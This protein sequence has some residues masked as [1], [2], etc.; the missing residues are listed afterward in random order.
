MASGG[1]WQGTQARGPAPVISGG[2]DRAGSGLLGGPGARL[3]DPALVLS[4]QGQILLAVSCR[5]TL[6]CCS[7][8]TGEDS[9]ALLGQHWLLTVDS[10][11]VGLLLEKVQ[12]LPGC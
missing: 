9:V 10:S 7:D 11:W 1:P 6:P 5:L 4:S 12:C 3:G 2:E 8:L